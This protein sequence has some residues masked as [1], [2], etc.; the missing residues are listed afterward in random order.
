MC[1]RNVV[2]NDADVILYVEVQDPRWGRRARVWVAQG[3]LESEAKFTTLRESEHTRGVYI[4]K[5]VIL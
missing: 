3:G 2:K 4:S 1:L 5:G